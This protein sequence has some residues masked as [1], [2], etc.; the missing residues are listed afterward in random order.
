L[1]IGEISLE[2]RGL[3]GVNRKNA[4]QYRMTGE[5]FL[6]RPHN[7]ATDFRDCFRSF[8]R[9]SC[10]LFEPAF[11]WAQTLRSGFGFAR[12]TTGWCTLDH[13]RDSILVASG[14]SLVADH[15]HNDGAL[16]ASNVA[17]EMND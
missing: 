7:A 15:G 6:V 8:R 10:R 9:S 1:S 2:G 4:K 14:L 17:F 16:T 3:D 11:C 13:G 5:R 12:A